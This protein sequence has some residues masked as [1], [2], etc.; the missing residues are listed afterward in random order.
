MECPWKHTLPFDFGF[1]YG[2][3]F[4]YGRGFEY[5]RGFGYGRSAR[6]HCNRLP[7]RSHQTSW[8]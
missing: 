4:A 8:V 6:D 1:V 3:G 7:A 5:G 2:R